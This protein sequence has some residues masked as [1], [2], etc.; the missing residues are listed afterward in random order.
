MTNENE[1]RTLDEAEAYDR[2]TRRQLWIGLAAAAIVVLVLILIIMESRFRSALDDPQ[3]SAALDE[4]MA[5]VVADLAPLPMDAREI[6]LTTRGE[7]PTRYEV[8]IRDGYGNYLY[9]M[10]RS[11]R[12][13]G[14]IE[15]GGRSGEAINFRVVLTLSEDGQLQGGYRPDRGVSVERYQGVAAALVREALIAW[16]THQSYPAPDTGER[17][18][19]EIHDGWSAVMD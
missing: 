7:Q 5:E 15:H 14:M 10:A 19:D 3:P 12:S 13:A 2:K 16:H 6:V 17:S 9:D 1:P 8:V 11:A 4:A 18:S